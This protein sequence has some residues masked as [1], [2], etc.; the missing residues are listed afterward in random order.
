MKIYERYGLEVL[1]EI[2]RRRTSILNFVLRQLENFCWRNKIY[3]GTGYRNGATLSGEKNLILE[4][5]IFV[6]YRRFGG[7]NSPLRRDLCRDLRP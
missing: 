6:N 2:Q 1:F 5:E 4:N 7:E 3:K